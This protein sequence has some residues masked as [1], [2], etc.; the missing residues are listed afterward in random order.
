MVFEDGK[1]L[2]RAVQAI[3][4]EGIVAKKLSQRYKPESGSG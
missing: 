3:G 2:F 1:R 4:L